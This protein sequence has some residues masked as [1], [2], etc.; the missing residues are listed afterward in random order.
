MNDNTGDHSS[1]SSRG[2]KDGKFDSTD[3]IVLQTDDTCT[4]R[5]SKRLMDLKKKQSTVSEM[6]NLEIENTPVDDSKK[7]STPA[8]ISASKRSVSATKPKSSGGR[9]PKKLPKLKLRKKN[10]NSASASAPVRSVCSKDMNYSYHEELNS[11]ASED[12]STSS[13]D[14]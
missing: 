2:E 1:I 8:K 5:S 4:T 14:E 7:V 12:A 11:S 6:I 13:Y 10:A 9:G 3:V